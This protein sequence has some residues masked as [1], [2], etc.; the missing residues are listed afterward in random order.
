[1]RSPTLHT[2]LLGPF[3]LLGLACTP[4]VPGYYLDLVDQDYGIE[5]ED[6]KP[7]QS[8]VVGTLY[9]YDGPGDP[10]PN[11]ILPIQESTAAANGDFTA[12]AWDPASPADRVDLIGTWVDGVGYD[13]QVDTGGGPVQRTVTR[14]EAPSLWDPYKCWDEC[15]VALGPPTCQFTPHDDGGAI[16]SVTVEAD[17]PYLYFEEYAG[18]SHMGAIGPTGH[19]ATLIHIPNFTP[20]HWGWV[21]DPVGQV[22]SFVY[23]EW[24]AP[25]EYPQIYFEIGHSEKVTCDVVLP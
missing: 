17:V 16:E 23:Q 15:W 8:T 14:L 13:L 1:M 20:P 10:S 21:S 7:L 6:F 25:L 4:E 9:E 24:T 19:G 11:R 12:T 22:L 2:T 5:I 18:P 3:L